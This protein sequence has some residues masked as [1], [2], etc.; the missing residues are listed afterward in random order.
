M[1]YKEGRVTPQ[2]MTTV[3][4]IVAVLYV[5]FPVYLAAIFLYGTY[6]IDWTATAVEYTMIA[7]LLVTAAV[8]I[9]RVQR[10]PGTASTPGSPGSRSASG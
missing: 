5:T 9:R 8:D 7:V 3:M 2:M 6:R 10:R 4:R 1:H